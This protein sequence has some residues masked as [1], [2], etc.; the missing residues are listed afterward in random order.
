MIDATAALHREVRDRVY[1][2]GTLKPAN[3]SK[4]CQPFQQPHTNHQHQMMKITNPESIDNHLCSNPRIRLFIIS[5]RGGR[6][7]LS[8]IMQ[9]L[10]TIAG[11]FTLLGWH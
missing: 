6:G 7:T 8:N 2:G 10:N 3:F 5:A 1:G 4:F 11:H 9:D